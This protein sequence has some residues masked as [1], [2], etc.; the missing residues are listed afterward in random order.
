MSVESKQKNEVATNKRTISSQAELM[1]IVRSLGVLNR[2]KVWIEPC[3]DPDWEAKLGHC[4]YVD[5]S[6]EIPCKHPKGLF[7]KDGKIHC[8][9]RDRLLTIER[10]DKNGQGHI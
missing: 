7:L 10:F 8:P 5:R 9:I 3:Y 2:I 4:R 6:G 1:S